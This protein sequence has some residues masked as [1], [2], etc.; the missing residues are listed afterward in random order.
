[1]DSL[2]LPVVNAF[3][4]E[5]EDD[6]SYE[7]EEIFHKSHR[8]L[9][10]SEEILSALFTCPDVYSKTVLWKEGII[11]LKE[12]IGRKLD[13]LS[14]M[15]SKIPLDKPPSDDNIEKKLATEDGQN[16]K[17]QTNSG[18]FANITLTDQ[19][20]EQHTLPRSADT[21]FGEPHEQESGEKVYPDEENKR[22]G[23]YT[24]EEPILKRKKYEVKQY[25]PEATYESTEKIVG[26]SS[27]KIETVAKRSSEKIE[28][29][30]KRSSEKIGT[31]AKRSSEKRETV[32]KISSKKMETIAK[33]ISEKTEPGTESSSEESND[34]SEEEIFKE[35]IGLEM[36]LPENII[37][38]G[39]PQPAL[40]DPERRGFS[41][42]GVF[43]EDFDEEQKRISIETDRFGIFGLFQKRYNNFPYKNWYLKAGK[44]V[45]L[46][47]VGQFLTLRIEISDEGCR[48]D[49]I[50][51]G[52][53][54]LPH[55]LESQNGGNYLQQHGSTLL[56]IRLFEEQMEPRIATGEH[57][58]ELSKSYSTPKCKT[59][60]SLVLVR[61]DRVIRLKYG[62]E[63]ESF[64]D[65]PVDGQLF[66]G[67]LF[68]L[69][70]NGAP[71]TS[72][73]FITESC[74]IENVRLLLQKCGLV[75]CG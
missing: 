43:I 21:S 74:C 55:L 67:T 63:E 64:S 45:E 20:S 1:M 12:A 54:A 52:E 30:A 19:T 22:R 73:R 29:V 69:V 37:Y 17:D 14:F 70:L 42:E 56:R 15:L 23:T 18:Q 34:S 4:T 6:L 51:P 60:D 62:E 25:H 71:Q 44:T 48:L 40:F 66:S 3:I 68:H 39:V 50:R 36:T 7:I 31:V 75:N 13:Y 35:S 38:M 16:M 65:E 49:S 27:E 57:R 32:A 72:E 10:I 46:S 61:P 11:N 24:R 5:W 28:T 41:T 8:S 2:Q 9:Q 26:R 53:I 59:E 58:N 33:R 47:L